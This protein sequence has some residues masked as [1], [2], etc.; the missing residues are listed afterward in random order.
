M[1]K[2]Q[3]I[4][5]S[6]SNGKKVLTD[7]D[8]VL[9]SNEIIVIVG[10]NGSG[11]STL[12]NVIAGIY[13]NKKN[14]ISI[15]GID[16]LKMSE[17]E[18]RKQIGI[19]FQN[20]NTQ[21]IFNNVYDDMLFT[22]NN[23][24]LDKSDERI[25]NALNLVGMS[26]MEQANPY[27]LSFGQKQRIAIANVLAINP[28]YLVLDEATSMLDNE[29]KNSIYKIVRD[30]KNQGLGI[31]FITN[32]IDEIRLADK[33]VF[34]K[35]G[36]VYKNIKKDD[37]KLITYLEELDFDLTFYYQVVKKALNG[38]RSAEEILGDNNV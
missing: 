2:L 24:N 4:N 1:I 19:V 38:N 8:L 6:Y 36:T 35:N 12:G 3:K 33:I 31:V 37:S 32:N 27:E 7:I 17:I 28:N 23:L 34:L 5:Y 26:G 11:K 10:K 18:I 15:N 20:P 22:L 16:I 29:G 14:N 9:N 25:T 21:I 30:L 13:K